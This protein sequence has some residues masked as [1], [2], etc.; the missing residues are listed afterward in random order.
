MCGKFMDMSVKLAITDNSVF[1]IRGFIL[2]TVVKIMLICYRRTI[3]NE[4]AMASPVQPIINMGQG[5]L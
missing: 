5:F 4:A 1:K 2:H 3:V